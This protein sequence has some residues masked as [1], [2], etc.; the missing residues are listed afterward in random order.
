MPLT[1]SSS[2]E[3]ETFFAEKLEDLKSTLATKSDIDEL[4]SLILEQ[5][6][7]IANQQ[8]EIKTLE[9]VYSKQNDRITV[10]ESQVSVLQNSVKLLKRAE[11]NNEQYNRRTCLRIRGIAPAKDEVNAS[12]LLKVKDVLKETGI[13]VPDNE[14]DRAHRIGKPFVDQKG[15]Q[16]HSVIV[17][18]KSWNTRTD[19]YRARK[20]LK[21]H[22]ISLDLTRNRMNLLNASRR[23][24]ADEGKDGGVSFV[25]ADVNCNIVAKLTTGKLIFFE[26][27]EQLKSLSKVT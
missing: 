9:E 10:L 17:K 1:R 22:I 25:F 16:H 27:L 8:E 20:K 3:L 24:L 23:F 6:K 4:K 19:V 12:C 15:V 5:G 14:I 11:D 21:N 26:T 7:I 18:F 2:S 13:E